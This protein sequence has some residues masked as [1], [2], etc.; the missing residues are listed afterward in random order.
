MYIFNLYDTFWKSVDLNLRRVQ[1]LEEGKELL[2]DGGGEDGAEV[3]DVRLRV[4]EVL[5]QRQ[6]VRQPREYCKLTL[7]L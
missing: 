1:V 5:Q 6:A 3:G 2:L 7:Q 4:V